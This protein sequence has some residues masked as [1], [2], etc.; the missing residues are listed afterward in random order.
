MT[1]LGLVLVQEVPRFEL[2]LADS[3]DH[4]NGDIIGT[5]VE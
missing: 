2:Q 3:T 1:L 4:K 5:W